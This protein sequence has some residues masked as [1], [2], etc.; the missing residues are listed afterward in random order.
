[1]RSR[2]R[3]RGHGSDEYKLQP[4]FFDMSSMSNS[5]DIPNKR[6]SSGKRPKRSSIDKKAQS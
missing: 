1:M 5:K 2:E 6:G 3:L 4:D